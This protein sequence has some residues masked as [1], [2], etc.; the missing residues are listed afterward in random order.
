[1]QTLIT[2]LLEMQALQIQTMEKM[3]KSIEGLKITLVSQGIKINNDL[4]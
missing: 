3:S 4:L 1:M 2:K